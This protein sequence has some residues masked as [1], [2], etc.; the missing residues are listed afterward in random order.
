[1]Q[2]RSRP[3]YESAELRRNSGNPPTDEDE[4]EF[5]DE[6]EGEEGDDVDD[7]H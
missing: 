3:W 4:D 5:D 7:E 6:E 1:M 2:L